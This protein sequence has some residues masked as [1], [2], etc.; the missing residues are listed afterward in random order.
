MINKNLIKSFICTTFILTGL[1]VNAQVA[2]LQNAIDKLESF[3]NYSYDYVYKQKEAFGDT[4]TLN[5]KYVLLRAPEDK[6]IGYFFI[7][8]RKYSDMDAPTTELY[9]GTNLISLNATESTYRT[10]KIQAMTFTRT[11][12]GELNWMKTFLKK[13]PSKILQASDTTFHAINSYHLI[14]NTNDTIINKD[15]LY[16]RIHLF[17]DKITGLPVGRLVRART[18]FLGKEVSNYYTEES[19]INYKIDQDNINAASFAIPKGFHQSKQKLQEK[20]VLLPPG[21]MAPD[22]T[23]YDTDGKKTSLSQLKGKVVLM[24]FFFVGCVPCMN[25]LAP[26]DR[27]HEK[28]KDKNV[29]I[30]SIS[31][32]DDKELVTAFKKSQLIKNQMYPDGGYVAKLYHMTDAP[33]FYFIDQGGKIASVFTGYSD[34]FE[35]KVTSVIENLLSK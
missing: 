12:Q 17:I 8:E 19:Y 6:D 34:D 32:R 25:T 21:M 5:E 30:L 22:W 33:T 29:V 20:I 16:T 14:L 7:H 28:Y 18:A 10:D 31:N 23:L 15:H 35:Q 9:N 4:L 1:Q 24:D 3:K 27:L 2:I 26:L 13:S 11:L